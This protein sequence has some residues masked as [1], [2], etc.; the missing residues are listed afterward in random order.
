MKAPLHYRMLVRRFVAVA[1]LAF[2]G[3][4]PAASLYVYGEYGELVD[5]GTVTARVDPSYDE[6]FD[7]STGVN[8][9]REG[10]EITLSVRRYVATIA[11]AKPCAG[12]FVVELGKLELGPWTAVLRVF[13]DDGYEIAQRI[14]RGFGIE[15]VDGRCG[16]T[17][18]VTPQIYANHKTLD[19]NAFIARLAA[20]PG[21]AATLGNPVTR[22]QDPPNPA[23]R[24]LLLA[25]PP[26]DDP[27]ARQFAL[28]DT[29][30]FEY[31]GRNGGFCWS[32]P[33]GDSAGTFVEFY[34][35]PLDHYFYTAAAS[36]IAAIEAGKVGPG[37]ART[38][39]SFRGVVFP[40]CAAQWSVAYRF[41]GMPDV[42]PSTHVFT[43]D[44]RECRK[45]ADNGL[46]LF[47]GLPLF[48]KPV[49]PDGTCQYSGDVPLHRIWR[50]FGVSNHRFTT[51]PAIVAATVARGWVHE[52]PVM[53]VLRPPVA[54]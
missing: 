47:E 2:A 48:A 28:Q 23:A 7:C 41:T 14:E 44:R 3:S 42:G 40:A 54:P 16:A 52:G 29:G 25:Y 35:T 33:P 53:C 49:Q 6:V 12:G 31:V 15:T 26:L 30:E 21:W 27:L 11:G 43:I 50:P 34:N 17:P 5:R 19:A 32:P 51:D 24:G 1:A 18:Y 4:A 39:Q 8:V 22:S 36:E 46:W 20:D 45:L 9:Y 10:R 13:V 37:W 38:G